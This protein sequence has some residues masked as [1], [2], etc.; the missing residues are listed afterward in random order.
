ME[1]NP[2]PGQQAFIRQAIE[3][4]RLDRPEAAIEEALSLWE[5]RERRRAEILTDIDEAR[6]SLAQGRG[7]TVTSEE[8][9]SQLAE[10]IK[11]RGLVRLNL[12]A[13]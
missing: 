8:E 5:A 4:G 9:S 1:V 6:T 12:P 13:R 2:T 3:S 10:G 7:Q 11:Q